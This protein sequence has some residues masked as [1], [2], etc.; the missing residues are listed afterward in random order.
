VRI[1]EPDVA[2]RE[3]KHGLAPLYGADVEGVLCEAA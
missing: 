1:D 3:L 2:V